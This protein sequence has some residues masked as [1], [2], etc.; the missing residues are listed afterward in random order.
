MP[1]GTCDPASRGD[2]FNVVE[3]SKG[4]GLVSVTVRYGWDGVSTRESENGC[5]GPLINGT[6]VVANRWAIRVVNNDAAVWYL[7]T[8]GRRGQPRDIAYQ[9]GTTTTYTANQATNAGYATVSDIADLSL[10]TSPTRG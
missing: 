5:D 2:A 3:M 4:N 10:S 1:A 6:G 8:T 7:H 9:P